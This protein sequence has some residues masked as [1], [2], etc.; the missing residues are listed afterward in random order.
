MKKVGRIKTI[1]DFFEADNGR[2]ISMEEFKALN[3]EDKQELAELAAIELGV[4][5]LPKK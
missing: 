3:E 4:E 2:K 1:K 5:L